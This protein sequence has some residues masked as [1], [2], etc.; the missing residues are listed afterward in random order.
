[1]TILA[2][3]GLLSGELVT[4][5]R[6]TRQRLQVGWRGLPHPHPHQL[7]SHRLPNRRQ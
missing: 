2:G 3:N 4:L 5:G 6:R 7:E 1:M